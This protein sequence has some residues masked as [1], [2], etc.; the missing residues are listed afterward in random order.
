MDSLAQAALIWD[1]G[2]LTRECDRSDAVKASVE[3]YLGRSVFSA[4]ASLLIRV[5]V[6][7]ESNDAPPLA[8]VT[9]EDGSGRTWGERSVSG[10]ADC[11]SLDDPLTLV[12]ALMI[13]S[14]SSAPSPLAEPEKLSEPSPPAAS[15]QPPDTTETGPIITAPSL[16]RA[17]YEPGHWVLLGSGSAAM[18]LLPNVG[19]GVGLD[20]WLKPSRFWGVHFG[21]ALLARQRESLDSGRIDFSVMRAHVGLCP[22]Q[23]VDGAAW[24]SA[25]GTFGLGRLRARSSRLAGART[26]VE[27]VALPGLSVTAG[28]LYRGWLL[29]G[30]GLEAAV[31]ISP[32]RYVYQD[33][34]GSSHLA[35][36]MNPLALTARVGVGVML[37]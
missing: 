36:Q 37:R 4:D 26:K 16:E 33:V 34:A 21:A 13:D 12:V 20:G 32:D 6:T 27:P 15:V 31:P 24:W 1:R 14:G 3:A 17:Q 35:F 29:L 10:G 22:L 9:Q 18:G 5:R 7:R 30:G 2:T 19:F 28:W 23:G 25:C 8:I 11:A